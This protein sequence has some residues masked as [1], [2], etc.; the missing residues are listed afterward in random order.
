MVLEI[1]LQLYHHDHFAFF[2]RELGS[3]VAKPA[4]NLILNG[5]IDEVRPLPCSVLCAKLQRKLINASGIA[6]RQHKYFTFPNIR[7]H[8]KFTIHSQRHGYWLPGNARNLNISSISIDV[9]LPT[10]SG[11]STKDFLSMLEQSGVSNGHTLKF[12][13]IRESRCSG[14]QTF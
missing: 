2:F 10:Y 14:W 11:L 6:L 9:T 1:D 3:I 8:G 7:R 13:C 5:C 12:G 4:V